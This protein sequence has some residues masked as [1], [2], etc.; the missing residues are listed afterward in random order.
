M[1]VLSCLGARQAGLL[2]AGM[3]FAL[4][5][6]GC[7]AIN[8]YPDNP[9]SS[10]TLQ[11]LRTTYFGA[12]ADDAYN[13]MAPTDADKRKALRDT[14]VLNRIRAFDAEFSL[15]QRA[16]TS[17]NNW[18]STGTDLTAFAL[19]GFGAVTGTAATKSALAAA[20]SGV[21]SAQGAVNKDLYYQKTISAIVTQMEANRG[22][23]K[24]AI[25]T[26]LK[27]S[28]AEYPLA[29]AESDLADLNDAGSLNGAI[30]SITQASSNEKADTQAKTAAVQALTFAKTPTSNKLRNWVQ[31]GGVINQDNID[32]L[33]GWLD[34][35]NALA[36]P[37]EACAKNL[38]A[39]L[40]ATT[41][42][43]ACDLDAMRAKAIADPTLKIP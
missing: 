31:P 36:I 15:F 1:N 35:E 25:F 8:A 9:D 26:S 19:N 42:S 32:A 14:I 34:K 30:S 16:L 21:M 27:L 22:K 24:L 29:R 11:G 38:S 18:F 17:D 40:F 6:T 3:L 39:P 43:A 28:D 33:Q 12:T 23:V 5:L 37:S 13:A 10:A 4:Q 7:A 2:C 41:T 20:S